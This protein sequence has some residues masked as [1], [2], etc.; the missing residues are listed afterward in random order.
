MVVHPVFVEH[1][2]SNGASALLKQPEERHKIL[3]KL[4]SSPGP[5]G[6]LMQLGSKQGDPVLMHSM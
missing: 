2:K 5:H 4:H 3:P 6:V 1:G